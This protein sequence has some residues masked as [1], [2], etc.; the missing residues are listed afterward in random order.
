MVRITIRIM[1]QI[2]GII[3]LCTLILAGFACGNNSGAQKNASGQISISDT[4]VI[5]FSEYEHDFGKIAAG[6]KVA[7]IFTF[8]NAGKGPLIINSVTT[9][10]GCTASKYSRK[11]VA[12][13][14]SG[15]IE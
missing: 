14:Q 12:P 11:P 10:C 1:K 4:A 3:F 2:T 15:T 7:A 9:S 6:E 8:T 13:G 5:V